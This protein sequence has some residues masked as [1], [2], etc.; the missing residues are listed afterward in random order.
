MV[1]GLSLLFFRQGRVGAARTEC[2]DANAIARKL[3]GEAL[4]EADCSGFGETVS[5]PIR[6]TDNAVRRTEIDDRSAAI[7][8]EMGNCC[9]TDEEHARDVR[10]QQV[11]PV[12]ERHL[13]KR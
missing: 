11:V 7:R 4:T 10:A 5:N 8:T 3:E 12:A 2:V 9:T 6:R 13:L 1:F